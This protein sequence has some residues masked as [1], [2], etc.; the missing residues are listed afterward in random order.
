MD[1]WMGA[2]WDVS[3]RC[4]MLQP[5]STAACLTCATQARI[6]ARVLAGRSSSSLTLPLLLLAAGAGT[7]AGV[8]LVSLT[9]LRTGGC[10]WAMLSLLLHRKSGR[11]GI[12]GSQP[13]T[14]ADGAELSGMCCASVPSTASAA[15]DVSH[16]GAFSFCLHS[17][18]S[19]S[20][21][22]SRQVS[23]WKDI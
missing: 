10:S 2:V 17:S 18:C 20:Q 23:G 15:A 8:L 3:G 12:R 9:L 4:S 7:A 14:A 19:S 11:A 13:C 6:Q 21:K 22:H 16:L 1:V 5:G